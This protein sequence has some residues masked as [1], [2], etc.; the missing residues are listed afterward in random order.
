V[1][2][3]FHEKAA[4]AIVALVALGWSQNASAVVQMTD[5]AF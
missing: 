4:D 2:G 1:R 3:T 5:V